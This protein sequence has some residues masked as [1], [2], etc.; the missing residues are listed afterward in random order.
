MTHFIGRSLVKLS[1][2]RQ[3]VEADFRFSLARLREFSEQV[4]LL[5]GEKAE[6][7]SLAQRFGAIVTNYLQIVDTKKRLHGV[8]RR[9]T[10]RSRRSSPTSLLRRSTSPATSRSAS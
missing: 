9:P 2:T 1:F 7:A 8:Y 3:R 10:V 5:G 4:A 6:K